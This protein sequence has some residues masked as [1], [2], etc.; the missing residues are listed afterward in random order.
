MDRILYLLSHGSLIEVPEL[1]PGH[2]QGSA[3]EGTQVLDHASLC[4]AVGH[5]LR[6]EVSS[7]GALV[8]QAQRLP[9]FLRRR[10]LRDAPDPG[11]Q[12]GPY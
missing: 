3:V 6:I 7:A 4:L 1:R 2:P 8:V 10:L 5:G 12:L 9:S 11:S